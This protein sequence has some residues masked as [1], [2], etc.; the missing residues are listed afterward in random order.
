[1]KSPRSSAIATIEIPRFRSCDRGLRPNVVL[2]GSTASTAAYKIWRLKGA[3]NVSVTR[4]T[5]LSLFE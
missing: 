1:V 4:L 5:E 2:E 3:S